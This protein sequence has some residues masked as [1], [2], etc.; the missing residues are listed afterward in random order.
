M[1]TNITIPKEQIAKFCLSN[2]ITRLALLGDAVPDSYPEYRVKVLVE[3]DP[4]HTPGLAFFRM[5]RELG[6]IIGHDVDLRTSEA[7]NPDF[8]QQ[9]LSEA[10]NIYAA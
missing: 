2:H 9:A 4:K 3:F 7:M 5:Q 6:K 8:K 10:Q 1:S